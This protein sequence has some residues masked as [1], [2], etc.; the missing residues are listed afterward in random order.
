V[1]GKVAPSLD[2]AALAE[3]LRGQPAD[4]IRA[5]VASLPGL[6]QKPQVEMW[7]AWAPT[8]LRVD[9]IVAAAR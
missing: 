7:P 6:R 2:T 5:R 4:A 8:A 9:V 1:Q 3:Q